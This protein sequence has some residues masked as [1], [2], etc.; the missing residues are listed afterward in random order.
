MGSVRIVPTLQGAAPVPFVVFTYKQGGITLSEAGVPTVNGLAFRM[1]AESLGT[2]GTPGNIQTGLA[3]ANTSTTAG[4]IV[5]ELMN[6]DGSSAGMIASRT[7]PA[8][9]QIVGFLSDFFPALPQ[10]FRGMLRISTTTSGVG[11]VGIR[12]RYNELGNYLMTTTSATNEASP[13]PVGEWL[14]PHIVNGGGFSTEFV[15]FSGTAGQSP[16]GQMRFFEDD[17][18]PLN[19]NIK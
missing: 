11:V 8:S 4:T 3:V 16:R 9:G 17:G 13:A 14:F 5:L 10:P 1:Y 12:S 6:I 7:L 19:I 2:L 15:L 18:S